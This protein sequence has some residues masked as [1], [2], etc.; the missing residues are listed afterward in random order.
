MS[1]F[2]NL[3]MPFA[4]RWA[5]L[6]NPLAGK[7][8]VRNLEGFML[9]LSRKAGIADFF[10]I[11]EE[12][13]F[14]YNLAVHWDFFVGERKRPALSAQKHRTS[15]QRVWKLE[16][17]PFL[18]NI[19]VSTRT[20]R[21]KGEG[22]EMACH[23]HPAGWYQPAVTGNRQ[24]YGV[25]V[26]QGGMVEMAN[27]L[28]A[29]CPELPRDIVLAATCHFVYCH[30]AAHASIE[31][32]CALLDFKRGLGVEKS[33]YARVRARTGG[34]PVM[35][36][37]LCDTWALAL[38]PKFLTCTEEWKKSRKIPSFDEKCLLRAIRDW[39]CDR[40]PNDLLPDMR[41]NHIDGVLIHGL[42]DL[43]EKIYGH[44]DAWDSVGAMF[45]IHAL[46]GRKNPGLTTLMKKQRQSPSGFG[47][48]EFDDYPVRV[49][50]R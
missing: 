10:P 3:L 27:E 11:P 39:V 23:M 18:E 6:D 28:L 35:E 49:H 14:I 1:E 46:R 9:G 31:D 5:G 40:Y 13:T 20:C 30:L 12:G 25:H 45:G 15:R 41:R 21:V 26:S 29:R 34:P 32:M 38:M 44:D 2:S 50:L 8:N 4:P 47:L 17:R 42:C 16:D 22:S 48:V 37:L 24:T 7:T 36:E 43:L 19:E 33:S